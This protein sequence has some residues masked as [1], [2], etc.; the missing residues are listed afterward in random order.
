MAT[1]KGTLKAIRKKHLP[2]LLG[3]SFSTRRVSTAD[4]G[5][6]TPCIKIGYSAERGLPP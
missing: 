4:G 1:N 5:W 6:W 3:F 2:A